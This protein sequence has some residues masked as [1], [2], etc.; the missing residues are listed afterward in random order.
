MIRKI[1]YFIKDHKAAIAVEFALCFPIF[2]LLLLGTLDLVSYSIAK[3]KAQQ[4]AV[5]F[6]Q[7]MTDPG[8]AVVDDNSSPPNPN[9]F[10]MHDLNKAFGSVADEAY[11]V[12]IQVYQSATDSLP[13]AE[14]KYIGDSLMKGEIFQKSTDGLGLI[15]EFSHGPVVIVNIL[16]SVPFQYLTQESTIKVKAI[17][18]PITQNFQII[19]AS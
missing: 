14:F 1:I 3:N 8:F 4:K 19:N 17:A 7:M 2:I 9:F 15:P 16:Q 13:Q 10:T 18:C 11:Q 6:A 5:V 12:E